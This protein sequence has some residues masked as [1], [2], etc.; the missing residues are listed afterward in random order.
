MITALCLSSPFVAALLILLPNF[1]TF[2]MTA[3]ENL[4]TAGAMAGIGLL[5]MPL[6]AYAFWFPFVEPKQMTSEAVWLDGAGRVYLDSL[7]E[8]A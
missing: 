6:M 7:P 1:V 3:A 5:F 4:R 2:S 8:I